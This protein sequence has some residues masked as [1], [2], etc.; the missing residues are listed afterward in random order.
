MS[1]PPP[2]TLTPQ[3][4]EQLAAGVAHALRPALLALE[5]RLA[6]LEQRIALLERR[7]S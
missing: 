5:Q 2:V 1:T 4:A 7:A 6:A 3:Q